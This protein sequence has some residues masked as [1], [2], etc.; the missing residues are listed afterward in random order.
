MNTK[1][2]R[3]AYA[4][5]DCSDNSTAFFS[6][7]LLEPKFVHQTPFT[8]LR[9]PGGMGI[10]TFTPKAS[11]DECS[12]TYGVPMLGVIS[13]RFSSSTGPI[14]GETLTVFGRGQPQ[15][16]LPDGSNSGIDVTMSY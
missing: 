2:P 16:T 6:K 8:D 9:T 5:Y 13:N 10:V 4:C 3:Y 7:S 15:L 11:G 14:A 1:I 12:A